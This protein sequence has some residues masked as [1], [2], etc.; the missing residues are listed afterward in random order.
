MNR[1][2]Y[3]QLRQ[4]SLHPITPVHTIAEYAKFK[5]HIH[6]TQIHRN[7][8]KIYPTHEANKMIDFNKFAVFWNSEVEKQDCTEVDSNKQLYY[9]LLSQ[10]ERH[11]KRIL[12]WKSECS[13]LL[14]GDNAVALKPFHDLLINDN[15]TTLPAQLP[16]KL[17]TGEKDHCYDEEGK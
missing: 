14:M 4:H 8:K 15:T 7:T 6:N 13:T 16:P 9:K 5:Q 2:C 11:H 1:Y 17:L 3:L 10:L 12:A